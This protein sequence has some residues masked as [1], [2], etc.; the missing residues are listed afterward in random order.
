MTQPWQ[1]SDGNF[2]RDPVCELCRRALGA[3]RTRKENNETGLGFFGT[4]NLVC[5]VATVFDALICPLSHC[6]G[7]SMANK[8]APSPVALLQLSSLLVSPEVIITGEGTGG[9]ILY[10]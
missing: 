4:V 2:R 5:S 9:I 10:L 8:G 6:R 1:M 3:S 7:T